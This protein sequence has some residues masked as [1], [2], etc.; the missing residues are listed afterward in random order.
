M[1]KGSVEDWRGMIKTLIAQGF[2]GL[3]KKIGFHLRHNG[4]L[5]EGL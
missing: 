4:K 1:E 5:W 3:G 2:M